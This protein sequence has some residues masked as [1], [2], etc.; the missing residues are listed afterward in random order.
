[1][2]QDSNTDLENFNPKDLIKR[3]NIYIRSS[4]QACI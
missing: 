2:K 1:M 3:K 4:F